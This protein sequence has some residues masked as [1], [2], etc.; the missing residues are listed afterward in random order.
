MGKYTISNSWFYTLAKRH[1]IDKTLSNGKTYYNK[2][3]VDKML[4][5]KKVDDLINYMTAIEIANDYNMTIESTYTFTSREKIPSIKI[6]NTTYYSKK[7]VH[8]A[9]GEIKKLE[10]DYYTTKEATKKYKLSRNALYN[11]I[12][13]HNIPKIKNG[14]YIYID[15]I[16]L[17]HLF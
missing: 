17:D 13:Y 1:K 11:L 3:Q 10:T 8:I 9:K 7:H 5:N 2:Q 16:A 15:K 6:K 14:K 12:R 4:G